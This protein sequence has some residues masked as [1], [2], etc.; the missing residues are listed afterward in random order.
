M[1]NPKAFL[2]AFGFFYIRD[3]VYISRMK[4]LIRVN[5]ILLK[6]IDAENHKE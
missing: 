4:R 3:D 1:K 5:M 6:H 2:Q